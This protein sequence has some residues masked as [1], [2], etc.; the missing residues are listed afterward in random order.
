MIVR[1]DGEIICKLYGE[2][3]IYPRPENLDLGAVNNLSGILGIL[4][5]FYIA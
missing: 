4:T 3:D 2:T 1:R 5:N